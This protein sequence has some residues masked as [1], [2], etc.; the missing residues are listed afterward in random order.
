MT[1]APIFTSYFTTKK[2][3]YSLV[4]RENAHLHILHNHVGEP[5]KKKSQKVEKVQ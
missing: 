3:R 2:K 5:L 4:P 1:L